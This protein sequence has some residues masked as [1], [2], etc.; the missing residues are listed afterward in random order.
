MP[1]TQD[2]TNKLKELQEN[3]L[4]EVTAGDETMEQDSTLYTRC[5]IY[6]S[7]KHVRCYLNRKVRET[8]ESQYSCSK[9]P[10]R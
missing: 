4:K 10:K 1:I 6:V 9:C 7:T 8:I 2:E 3:E 5:A